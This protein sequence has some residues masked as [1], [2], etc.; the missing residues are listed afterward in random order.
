MGIMITT[1]VLWAAGAVVVLGGAGGILWKTLGSPLVKLMSRTNEFLD[2]WFGVPDRDG[3]PGRKGVM[4]RLGEVE[5]GK[6]DRQEIAD[7]V[8]AITEKA[9]RSE[10][11]ALREMLDAHIRNIDLMQEAQDT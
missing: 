8:Q 10:V 6:A 9:D 4:V 2:D 11:L 3:V 5:V 7:L 1:K